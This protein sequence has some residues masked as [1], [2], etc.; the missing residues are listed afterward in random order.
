MPQY[1]AVKDLRHD[2]KIVYA[3]SVVPSAWIEEWDGYG[4]NTITKMRR[5]N[6]IVLIPGDGEHEE[7][8]PVQLNV[9]DSISTSALSNEKAAIQSLL[10]VMPESEARDYVRDNDMV[11]DVGAPT[12]VD[13]EAVNV[14]EVYENDDSEVPEYEEDFVPAEHTVEEVKQFVQENPD[15]VG[16]VMD[17]E[18]NG[19]NRKSLMT[20]L[21]QFNEEQGGED[22]ADDDGDDEDDDTSPS[23]GPSQDP[24]KV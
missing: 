14:A 6:Q 15:T 16:D 9:G 18:Y 12:G 8:V 13:P 4:N 19:K 20:W 3:G 24:S 2:G 1:Q 5:N 11:A 17:A 22:T 10:G 7:A 21:E 23:T